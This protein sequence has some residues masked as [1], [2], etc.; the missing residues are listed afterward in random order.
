MTADI[1]ALF[2]HAVLLWTGCMPCSLSFDSPKL[3]R[4]LH[5]AR[6][7]INAGASELVRQSHSWPHLLDTFKQNAWL[8][9]CRAMT[10]LLPLSC[11]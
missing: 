8:A 4:T 5:Y 6:T 3:V 11:T 1:V 2:T 7:R 10:V 9:C